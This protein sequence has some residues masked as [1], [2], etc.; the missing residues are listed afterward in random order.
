MRLVIVMLAVLVCAD[1]SAQPVTDGAPPVAESAPAEPPPVP[2]TGAETPREAKP[3]PASRE[4][5]RTAGRALIGAGSAAILAG[6]G[7]AWIARDRADQA[8]S[9][10]G[11]WDPQI[12]RTGKQAEA[13]R[14]G[15]WV[16][17]GIA[18]GAGIALH[19]LGRP[20]PS[21]ATL[22][23]V[24]LGDGAIVTWGGAL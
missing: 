8:E 15:L 7:F 24:P 16:G 1:A 14:T 18:I 5:R 11:G 10:N 3:Q 22:S 6:A 17:G 20:E 9:G 19:V 2:Q 12:E 23:L 13:A 21:R 4:W